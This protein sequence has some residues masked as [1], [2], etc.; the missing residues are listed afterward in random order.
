MTG[1]PEPTDEQ[2]DRVLGRLG[3]EQHRRYF[4]ERLENPRW[5]RPLKERGVFATPPRPWTDAKGQERL[6]QWPEAGYLAR[7][8]RHEPELAAEIVSTAKP[9]SNSLV[10]RTFIEVALAVPAALSAGLVSLVRQWLQSPSVDWLDARR[11]GELVSHLARGGQARAAHQLAS[12]LILMRTDTTS[13]TRPGGRLR[14]RATQGVSTWLEPY[15]YASVLGTMLP[16]LAATESLQALELVNNQ[17]ETWL[18]G[19]QGSVADR[20]DYSYVWRPSIAPHTQN[21]GG[22]IEDALI[23]AARDTARLLADDPEVQVADVVAAFE[24]RRWTLFRRLALNLLAELISVRQ[25]SDPKVFDLARERVLNAE[26]LNDLGLVHEYSLL[27]GALLPL[28]EEDDVD[29]WGALIEA[30]PLVDEA[31]LRARL[32]AG[33]EASG[34][35]ESAADQDRD[36]AKAAPQ[37]PP[38]SSSEP[39]REPAV[40]DPAEAILDEQVQR[41]RDGWRRDR[42]GAV[43]DALPPSLQDRYNDLARHMGAAEHSDFVSYMTTWVGPTSPLSSEELA[44]LDI[45]ELIGYLRQWRP[46]PNPWAARPSIEG[47]ARELTAVVTSDPSRFAQR[48]AEFISCGPSFA[49]AVLQ[50]LEGALRADR[51]FPW[52]SVVAL[53]MVVATQTDDG[54][55][56]APEDFDE[57]QSWRW[58]QQAAASLL[59]MGLEPRPGELPFPLGPQVLATLARLVESPHPTP[60]HEQ[61]YGDGNMD[62]VTQALNTTRGQAL[63]GLVLYAAWLSRHD[64]TQQPEER[65]ASAAIGDGEE[66]STSPEARLSEVLAILDR[67]LDPSI[68]RS[69]AV[70]SMYGLHFQT[71]LYVV[72]EWAG[73]RA[74]RIFG[75]SGPLDEPQK[76]AAAAF[77]AFNGPSASL[78]DAL[79]LQYAMWAKALAT[80]TFERVMSYSPESIP[81]R[82]AEHLLFLYIW[83]RLELDA[84]PLA[85]FF[86]FAPVDVRR[87]ALA[88][89]GGQLSQSGQVIADDVLTRLQRLWETRRRVIG[90]AVDA[91]SVTD[92]DSNP[93]AELAAFG[94]WFRSG[95]FDHEWA[96]NELLAVSDRIAGFDRLDVDITEQLAIAAQ[97]D[98]DIALRIYERLL[99]PAQQNWYFQEVAREGFPILAAALKSGQTDLVNRATQLMNEIASWGLVDARERVQA[100]VNR[101]DEDDDQSSQPRLRNV[102]G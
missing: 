49:R 60:D 38:L 1:W 46:D 53:C 16:D 59:L 10:H 66:A 3:H 52:P 89:V 55:E 67:H 25:S 15:D 18:R 82:L 39:G 27:T 57:D 4:F 58:A 21:L 36:V 69:P 40:P 101:W 56:P 5:L 28:L 61:R 43:Q 75:S 86:E 48:A 47:L 73:S 94:W 95:R 81:E 7:M 23:D 42:L 41:F 26:N 35:L 87:D 24:R 80:D 78:L 96:I 97:T 50:G 45:D 32:R 34:K 98:P 13:P 37:Q 76:A 102:P 31:A 64:P 85:D 83:G 12:D 72:P 22:T 65:G 88:N 19:G 44:A 91:Q 33:L 84:S 71:L 30:G 11:L 100:I 92:E 2:V 51:S 74:A 17:L 70:R 90:E 68:D 8:A 62:P 63:R 79:R 20:T 54:S 99:R 29:A 6:P 14:T 9:T 93:T 77:L